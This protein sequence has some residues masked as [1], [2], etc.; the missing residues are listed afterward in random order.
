MVVALFVGFRRQDRERLLAVLF[1]LKVPLPEKDPEV[2][3]L[4]GVYGAA[5]WYEREVYDMF[6]IRFRG[7]PNLRRILMYEGFQGHPLRKDYPIRKRQP[8]IGPKN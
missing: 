2:E 1:R 3:T 5:D 7:H 4:S 8:I 6:G